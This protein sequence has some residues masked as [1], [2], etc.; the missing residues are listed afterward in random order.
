MKIQELTRNTRRK[1]GEA[2]HDF[3]LIREGD[4]LMVGL[5]GGKDSLLLLVSLKGLQSRSPVSFSIEACSV[6][7]TDGKTDLS[8]IAGLCEAMEIPYTIV[9]VPIFRL[10]EERAE[11]TPCSF[12]ANMRRG[13]LSSTTCLRDCSTLCL[14]HH[15]DDIVETT[16]MNL[17]FSGRFKCFTPLTWQDRTEIRVIRPLVY[18]E[19][20][21]I[22]REVDRLNLPVVDFRCPFSAD[23]QRAWIKSQVTSMS[24]SVMGMKHNVLHALK[25]GAGAG[26][27]WHFHL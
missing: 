23:S 14:G 15:L 26:E 12:C 20:V 17:L 1:I 22:T 5:S 3:S 7:P 24:K 18:L 27:G 9:P 4:R 21:Q 16:L 6:D 11:K 8:P 2:I 13:I 10:V 25:A 19:E